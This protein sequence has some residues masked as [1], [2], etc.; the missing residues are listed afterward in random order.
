MPQNLGRLSG[1]DVRRVLARGERWGCSLG[2]VVSTPSSKSLG[3]LAVV[4]SA[5]V[6][7][8]SSE[9][10]RIRRRIRETLRELGLGLVS[11]ETV[12]LVDAK[13]RNMPAKLLREGARN[14][15]RQLAAKK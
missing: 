4:V 9:R 11:R 1:R 13:V 6:S 15:F 14:I 5:A 2:R 10:N 8:K 12:I 7:K 3:R